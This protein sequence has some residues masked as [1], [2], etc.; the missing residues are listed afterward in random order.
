M[1][2][3]NSIEKYINNMF[4]FPTS[5]ELPVPAIFLLCSLKLLFQTSLTLLRYR[6]SLL[7]GIDRTSAWLRHWSTV[8][9]ERWRDVKTGHYNYL[10]GQENMKYQPQTHVHHPI[11]LRQITRGCRR[12]ETGKD[13]IMELK[14]G[15]L[16]LTTEQ[17]PCLFVSLINTQLL[18]RCLGLSMCPGD[19]S[20]PV[21]QEEAGDQTS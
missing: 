13:Y 10:R 21:N 16:N 1:N 5:A 19:V 2:K 7:P 3:L 8:R 12:L 9:C 11:K 6:I 20:Q 14:I 18:A 4:I 15:N 17:G